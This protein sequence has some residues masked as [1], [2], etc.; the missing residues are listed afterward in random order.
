MS[1]PHTRYVIS[2]TRNLE[3]PR[4]ELLIR[5][6]VTFLRE[7]DQKGR[8]VMAGPFE[9]GGGG[10]IIIRADSLEAATRLAESDPFVVGGY[11]SCEVRT[12]LLSCEENNHMGMG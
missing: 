2:L 8:L 7:L 9:D 4:D 3:K 12:W 10:M 11:D 1:D 5:K 6:H